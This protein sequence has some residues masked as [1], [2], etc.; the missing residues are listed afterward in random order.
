MA[1]AQQFI[2]IPNRVIDSRGLSPGALIYF[3]LSGT[4]TKI[5]VYTDAELSTPA[6]N[7]T[8]VNAGAAVPDRFWDAGLTVRVRVVATTGDVISDED[9]WE[10]FGADSLNYLQAGTGAVYRTVQN[11]LR[12]KLSVLD[13][14]ADPTGDTDSYD[15]IIAA[16]TAAIA[17]DKA[18]VF[19]AGNYL[20]SAM[21]NLAWPRGRV[22]GAGR[23]VLQADFD[24]EAVVTLDGEGEFCYQHSFEN[25]VLR[26]NGSAN[27]DGLLVRDYAQGGLSR[28]LIRNVTKI[29]FNCEGV[30][31]CQIVNCK[32]SYRADGGGDAAKPLHGFAFFDSALANSSNALT[33]I[34]CVVH[35]AT[36]RGFWLAQ[37]NDITMIGCVAEGLTAGLGLAIDDTSSGHTI[38]GFFAELNGNGDLDCDGYD[39]LFTGCSFTSRAASPPYDSVRS[40]IFGASSYG[41]RIDGGDAYALVIEPGAMNNT[42]EHLECY[43][44]TDGGE[45]SY[46]YDPSNVISDVLQEYISSSRYQSR[47][48]G[49]LNNPN[50]TQ[51][52]WYEEGVASAG[53]GGTTTNGTVTQSSTGAFT[54]IGDRVLF[55]I[56]TTVSAVGAAPTGDLQLKSNLPSPEYATEV[57]IMAGGLTYPVGAKQLAARFVSGTPN[58]TIYSMDG[59]APAALD[60]S[61]L[62]TGTVNVSGHY[63]V[64]D[65]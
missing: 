32:V 13:F 51:L 43:E 45:H 56:Q 26:G 54:R 22:Y 62:G 53:W 28:I 59:T 20:L 64:M 34:G 33:M 17:Q 35:D 10:G 3:Y 63:K 6:A 16:K 5:S 36:Q 21:P 18:L 60:G 25:F 38:I 2:Y 23:V 48:F 39:S 9:P 7:P 15:A 29:G 1:T 24:G 46:G 11:R 44:I 12:E 19:P 4:T 27:Q 55:E 61:A 52:D 42:I 31:E 65:T 40:V 14:G 49:N 57:S 58:I 47:N 41:N 50:P 8:V 37:V 30:V